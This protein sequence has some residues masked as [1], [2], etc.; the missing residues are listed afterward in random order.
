MQL[1]DRILIII[2]LKNLKLF[3]NM[4]KKIL[5]AHSRNLVNIYH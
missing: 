2:Q 1:T 3:I 4:Y 5:M